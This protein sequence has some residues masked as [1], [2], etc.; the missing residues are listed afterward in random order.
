MRAILPINPG[1][2]DR[3]VRIL[4]PIEARDAGGGVTTTW[5]NLGPHW[6]EYTPQTGREIQQAGQKLALALATFRIR[7]RQ[8]NAKWRIL[9]RDTAYE[10]VAPPVEVGRRFRMD[11]VCQAI[12]PSTLVFNGV[13][14][15]GFI[16]DLVEGEEFKDIVYDLPFTTDPAATT[17]TLLVPGE[18]MV[19]EVAIDDILRDEF[20]FRAVFG[21]AVPGPGY[22]LSVIAAS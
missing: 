18:G 7:Y 16:I 19:F 9:Y 15:Q 10:L 11:L 2:L 22:R 14:V 4:S 17:I 8:I 5:Q 12:D 21:A 13:G 1:T 3:R 20:G 6:A